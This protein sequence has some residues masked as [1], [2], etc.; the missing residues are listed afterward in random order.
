MF[1]FSTDLA[2][3]HPISLQEA[4]STFADHDP[5]GVVFKVNLQDLP[6][7]LQKIPTLNDAYVS[8][9]QDDIGAAPAAGTPQAVILTAR[10]DVKDAPATGNLNAYLLLTVGDSV[11]MSPPCNKLGSLPHHYSGQFPLESVFKP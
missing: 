8:G 2:K 4:K 10:E 3:Y 9:I 1:Q 7:A 5:K 11:F 6:T